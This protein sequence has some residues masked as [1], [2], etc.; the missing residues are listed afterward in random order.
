[1]TTVTAVKKKTSAFSLIEVMVAMGIGGVIVA[2][3]VTS[4]KF[5]LDEQA[6][7]KREWQAFTIAQQQMEVL[8]SLP[9]THAL[10]SA[11]VSSAVAAGSDADATCDGIANGLQRKRVDGLG[12]ASATGQF[13]LCVKIT[14]GSPFGSKKNIRVV[15]LFDAGGKRHVLLQ[16]IR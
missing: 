10:L 12:T 5:S 7:A 13:D 11:N 4:F 15:V 1:M 6:R 2:S 14:D 16:T 3:A 9:T 8:S